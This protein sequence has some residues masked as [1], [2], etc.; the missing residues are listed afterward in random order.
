MA[1]NRPPND[2]H[3]GEVG[4]ELCCLYAATNP[5]P[6]GGYE[7]AQ[8]GPHPT[9]ISA[10]WGPFGAILCLF[11]PCRQIQPKMAKIDKNG[12]KSPKCPKNIFFSEKKICFPIIIFAIILSDIFFRFF[13][14][15]FFF[16]YFFLTDF[17]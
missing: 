10:I 14:W 11:W 7:M 6:M 2:R 13:F 12:H 3:G 1:P 15:D 4:A 9:P 5:L 8:P 17:E 16:I